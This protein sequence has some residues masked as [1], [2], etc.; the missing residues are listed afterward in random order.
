MTQHKYFDS[1]CMLILMLL[2]FTLTAEPFFD[3]HLHYNAADAQVF[4][5]QNIIDKLNRSNIRYA[6][7]TGIP[8]SH[9][10]TL[11][12]YAPD[13]IVPFLSVARNQHDKISWVNNAA[14]LRELTAELNQ[15]SWHGIG[16]LHI[17]ANDRHSKVFR[18]IIEIA[19]ERQLP[20][21]LH[22]DPAV[23]DTVYDIAADVQV[24]WA[25]AGTFPYPDLIADYLKRYPALLIDL[26][27]RDQRIA[28]DGQLDD[29]WYDLLLS[30]PESFMAGV[31]TY[32]QSR[33]RNFDAAVSTI[34]NWLTLLPD[35]VAADIAYGN[36]ARLFNKAK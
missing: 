2:P 27:M 22:C 31:D 6:V 23:I 18:R 4:S 5:P 3:T 8:S 36:A 25:H 15:G 21:L 12:K 33:W 11:Y 13:R 20:V 1:G 7:V 10:R 30:Y 28:P 34:S 9:T 29:A 32:S 19:A 26:S 16:E 17:F 24:I 14:L 35:D